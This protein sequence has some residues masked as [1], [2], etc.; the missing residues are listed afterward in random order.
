MVWA[1]KDTAVQHG[2]DIKMAREKCPQALTVD[3]QS[4]A[5]FKAIKWQDYAGIC[6]GIVSYH[7]KSKKKEK[8]EEVTKSR[9]V[10]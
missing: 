7:M 2:D 5:R 4:K 10:R 3:G 6:E 1:R 8:A 9:S